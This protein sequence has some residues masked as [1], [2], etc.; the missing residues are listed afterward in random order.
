MESVSKNTEPTIENIAEA[1]PKEPILDI[2]NLNMEEQDSLRQRI[3][4]YDGLVRIFVHPLF[5]KWRGNEHEYISKQRPHPYAKIREIEEV[6]A[7]LASMETEDTPP[8][9]IFEEQKYSYELYQWLKHGMPKEAH[10]ELYLVETHTKSSDPIMA[11]KGEGQGWNKLT[12][13]FQGLGVKKILLGGT[14][15]N[16]IDAKTRIIYNNCVGNL[17]EHLAKEKGGEFAIELSSLTYPRSR[18]DVLDLKKKQEEQRKD[19]RI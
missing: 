3:K 10:N 1:A 8:I 6:L 4:K 5:D 7:N 15:L 12:T 2:L 17:F 18:Q 14:Q 19:H 9:I 11:V 16:L 13:L